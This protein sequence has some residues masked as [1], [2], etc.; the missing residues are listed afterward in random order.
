MKTVYL[1]RHAKSSWDDNALPDFARPLA[2]RGRT[3]AP[4]MGR[5]MRKQGLLPDAVLCSGAR[6][7]VETWNIIAPELGTP[8]VQI[9]D[10][11]YMASPDAILAWLRRLQPEIGSVLLIGHN[12]G[13]E[14][15]AVRLAIDGRKKAL[16]RMRTKYPTGTLAVIRFDVDAWPAVTDGAGYLDRF[17]RPKD[18]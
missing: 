4:R 12:P 9:D 3:A 6:R 10:D 7:A 5:Y 15:L 18:L 14:E 17:V 13:F 16:E 1:L 11:L 8:R 2:D